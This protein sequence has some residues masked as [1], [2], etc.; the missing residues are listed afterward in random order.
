MIA[1]PSCLRLLWHEAERAFSRACA[2][3]GNRMA[4]RIAMMAITTS[5]SINVNPRRNGFGIAIPPF[6]LDDD[7]GRD[8]RPADSTLPTIGRIARRFLRAAYRGTE[9]RS[10]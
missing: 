7:P 10:I 3:T 4:A 1:R 8:D 6:L 9:P 2:N 5:S